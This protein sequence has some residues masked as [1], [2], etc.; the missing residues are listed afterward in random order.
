MLEGDRR[1]P[2]LR[3]E[4]Q[5]VKVAGGIEIVDLGD[6]FVGRAELRLTKATRKARGG[7][8][9]FIH[10]QRGLEKFSLCACSKSN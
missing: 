10:K 4:R 1:V 3:Q 5:E 2:P 9:S 7:D 6:G 8:G